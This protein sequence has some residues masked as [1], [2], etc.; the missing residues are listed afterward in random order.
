MKRLA[1]LV[2]LVLLGFVSSEFYSFRV[3]QVQSGGEHRLYLPIFNKPVPPFTVNSTADATDANPGDSKCETVIGNGVCTLRAAIQEANALPGENTINLP[4][5]T[6]VLTIPGRQEDGALTGDLDVRDNLMLV[7]NDVTTTIVDGNQLDRVFDVAN[8]SMK[9]SGIT[10]RNGYIESFAG[11]FTCGGGG[12]Y[13]NQ[14]HV[15]LANSSVGNNTVLNERGGGILNEGSLLLT[16]STIENNMLIGDT[17]YSG[18]GIENT[19]AMSIVDSIIQ[20]NDAGYGYGGGVSG[21]SV[22]VSGSTFSGNRA[23]VGGGG[24]AL[25][26]ESTILASI[27]ANNEAEF[28][29]DAAEGGGGLYLGYN[30]LLNVSNTTISDNKAFPSGGGIFAR[31]P[32]TITN[33]TIKDNYAFKDGGGVYQLGGDAS[34]ND[35]TISNNRTEPN[36]P[37]FGGGLF[38]GSLM[39]TIRLT[40]MTI[41]NNISANGGGM[42]VMGTIHIVN[43]TIAGN[44]AVG[45][46]GSG[47]RIENGSLSLLNSTIANNISTDS[48]GSGGAL[49]TGHAGTTTITNS[50][51]A[52]NARGNCL[53]SGPLTGV[54]ISGGYNLSSDNSCALFAPGDVSNINAM[55]GPLQNNGGPTA[56]MAPLPGS[57][58]ID[59]GNNVVCPATDQRDVPRPIDGDHDGTAVCDKGAVEFN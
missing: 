3:L 22:Y 24:L 51:L 44:I 52:N 58:V 27:I 56:T 23:G 29:G 50:I 49:L 28:L 13:N 53:E 17:L 1:F 25:S 4:T 16:N 47:V 39:S 33:S 12:I 57:P 19:G 6:Y 31:S 21:V 18:G 2:I 40:N 26:G 37:Y 14:G 46:G 34:F 15:E 20:H 43:S 42:S 35:V 59:S 5:G 9:M 32:I 38:S 10:I 30:S 11:C 7:G 36:G 45:S 55:L 54:L 41:A 8:T 48:P